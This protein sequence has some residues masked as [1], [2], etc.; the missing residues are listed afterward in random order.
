MRVL[1]FTGL[2]V[3]KLQFD[4]CIKLID[5][6]ASQSTYIKSVD[7]LKT[8]CYHQAGAS[9]QTHA[10]I[11]LMT[12]SYQACIKRAAFCPFSDFVFMCNGSKL[13]CTFCRT[14]LEQRIS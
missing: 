3:V 6:K 10:Y 1:D 8:A 13:V 7:N 12:A 5:K 14:L 9:E 2:F 4:I 11:G